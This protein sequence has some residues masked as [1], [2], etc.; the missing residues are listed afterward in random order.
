MALIV[1]DGKL[2]VVDGKLAVS[3]DCCCDCDCE[4]GG[5]TAEFTAT[6]VDDSPCT[7]D[8]VDASIARSCG[9]IVAWEWKQDGS[10]FSTAQNPS[11]VAISGNS[12]TIELTVTDSSGCT[13]TRTRPAYCRCNEFLAALHAGALTPSVV[14]NGA[15]WTGGT[16][17]TACDS[18]SGL[19]ETSYTPPSSI[20]WQKQFS[21]SGETY[22]YRLNVQCNCESGSS[23]G[24]EVTLDL[25]HFTGGL[26]QTSAQWSDCVDRIFD[27]A[28]EAV[29]LPLITTHAV[30]CRPTNTPDATVTF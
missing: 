1:K 21:F 18:Q 12:S 15:S 3:E 9:E 2:L 30:G 4:T 25:Q 16:G 14:I 5:P 6:R 7:Y 28:G 20:E 19:A 23:A 17:C 29:V 27:V 22:R 11:G 26:F 8:F 13:S 10:T 24:S